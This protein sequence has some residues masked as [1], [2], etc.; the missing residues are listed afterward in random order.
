[1]IFSAAGRWV[2]WADD[3]L[4]EVGQLVEALGGALL[5]LRAADS[6]RYGTDSSS[7]YGAPGWA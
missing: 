3:L 5:G 1:V 6:A 4:G 2:I 7:F